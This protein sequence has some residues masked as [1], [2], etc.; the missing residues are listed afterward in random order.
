MSLKK[1]EENETVK[2][3]KENDGQKGESGSVN[4]GESAS[5]NG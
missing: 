2:V 3:T 4:G 5:I 1:N